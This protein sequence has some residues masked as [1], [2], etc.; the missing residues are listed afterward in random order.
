MGLQSFKQLYEVSSGAADFL[1]LTGPSVFRSS[2][3]FVGITWF[4]RFLRLQMQSFF[5]F[6]YEQF[7]GVRAALV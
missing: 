1:H 6:E 2:E 4:F 3:F 7:L 5:S